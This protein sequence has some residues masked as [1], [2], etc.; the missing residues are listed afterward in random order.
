LGLSQCEESQVQ[1]YIFLT[2]QVCCGAS[3]C[4]GRRLV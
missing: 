3:G 4:G 2:V 1:T